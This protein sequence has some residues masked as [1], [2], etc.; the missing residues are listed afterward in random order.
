MKTIYALFA[1]MMLLAGCCTS[2]HGAEATPPPVAE[3]PSSPDTCGVARF[4]SLIGT[5][6]DAIDRATLPPGTRILTPTSI[7]TRDFRQDRLNIMTG[8]DGKVSSLRCY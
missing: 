8:A 3:Q 7:V 6:A 2:H 1:A 4:Q 5:P